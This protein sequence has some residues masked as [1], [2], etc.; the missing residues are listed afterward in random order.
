MG[1]QLDEKL[2]FKQHGSYVAKKFNQNLF[3]L[4]SN[5]KILPFHTRLLL[6]N[7]L[8]RP[9]LDYG[10]EIWGPSNLKT[11][12]TLQKRAIRHVE[13]TKNYMQHTNNLF[14]KF[15]TLKFEDIVKYHTM[16]LGYKLVHKRSPIGLK[17]NMEKNGGKTRRKNDLK[18]SRYSS[19]KLRKLIGYQGP[20]V[21]N[22]L[23]EDIKQAKSETQAKNLLK[24]SLLHYYKNLPPCTITNC[25]SCMPNQ[26]TFPQSHP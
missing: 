7:S 13:N 3:L 17:L 14:V 24:T 11:I 1:I 19:Q 6:Y 4:S 23:N 2:T 5:K 20:K 12:T 8:I 16:R 21:W 9:H 25:P 10:A 18:Q 22:E 26:P 15:K